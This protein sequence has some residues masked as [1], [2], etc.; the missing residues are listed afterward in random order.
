MEGRLN[1]TGT[2][3][4]PEYFITDGQ[5]NTRFSFQEKITTASYQARQ[6][7]SYYPF[8]LIMPNST[9]AGTANKQLYNGGSEWQNDYGDLPDLDQT[10]YRNYDPALGRFVGIDPMAEATESLSPYHY[11]GNNPVMFND[12][13]GDYYNDGQGHVTRFQGETGSD[14]GYGSFRI[15]ENATFA[16]YADGGGSG[17]GTEGNNLLGLSAAQVHDYAAQHGGQIFVWNPQA[18]HE[19]TKEEW[20]AA[21]GDPSKLKEVDGNQFVSGAFVP[22]ANQGRWNDPINT[23][24]I[25]GLDSRLQQPATDF[26]NWAH[27]AY[28]V[29]LRITQGY[30]SI[31]DQNAKYAQGRTTPGSIIT[32]AKGGQSYHQYGLAFDVVIMNNGVPNWSKIVS[33]DIVNLAKSFGFEWGGSWQSFKDNPHFQMTFGQTWQQLYKQSQH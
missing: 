18:G 25:A 1:N 29:D 12:P 15:W 24:M 21:G 22:V 5:G 31:A 11:A 17:D 27:Y 23:K 32:N 19:I 26:L 9:V 30:R 20:I 10:F 3:L 28:G 6:E 8:G 4:N 7:N 33:P 13:M 2:G 14:N 16:K